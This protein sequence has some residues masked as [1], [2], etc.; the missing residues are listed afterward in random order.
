M[1]GDITELLP[2]RQQKNRDFTERLV[3][4]DLDLTLLPV[5]QQFG[6]IRRWLATGN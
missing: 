1:G 3:S 5:C 6:A 2:V 4:K